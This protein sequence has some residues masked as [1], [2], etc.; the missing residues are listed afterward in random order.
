[1]ARI[2]R[3]YYYKITELHFNIESYVKKEENKKWMHINPITKYTLIPAAVVSMELY[4][5]EA[6]FEESEVEA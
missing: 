4:N 5:D 3:E 6:I 1:M 2:K